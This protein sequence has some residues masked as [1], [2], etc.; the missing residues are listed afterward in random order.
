MFT[1]LSGPFLV[2]FSGPFYLS[3]DNKTIDRNSRLFS[4]ANR[5]DKYFEY[6]VGKELAEEVLKAIS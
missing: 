3:T 4:T 5:L 1:F 6:V 2:Q